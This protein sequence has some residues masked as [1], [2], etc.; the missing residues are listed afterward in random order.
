MFVSSDGNFTELEHICEVLLGDE[1]LDLNVDDGY[2]LGTR[3][4]DILVPQ[5]ES[6]DLRDRLE[7]CNPT[8]PKR[9]L[10]FLT[11]YTL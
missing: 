11:I 6:M 4:A 1:G 8:K 2:K 3:I 5:S 7:S 10:N 9:L